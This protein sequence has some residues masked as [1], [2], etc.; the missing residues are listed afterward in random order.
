MSKKLLATLLAASMVGSMFAGFTTQAEELG[1]PVELTV[2][3]TAVSTDTHAQA[4]L[5]FKEACEELSGGNITVEVYTDAQLIN[6]EEE[7]A[8]VVSIDIQ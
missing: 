5:K 4:M 2:T 3:L 8:A 1:D 6:Q 7:V